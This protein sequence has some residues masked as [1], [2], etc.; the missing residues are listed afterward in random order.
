MATHGNSR[1]YS[2]AGHFVADDATLRVET[3]AC[4]SWRSVISTGIPIY[5]VSVVDEAYRLV[6]A[7][8]VIE[9]PDP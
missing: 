3:D 1:Q 2:Q 5:N 8:T 6:N 7:P 9:M 4:E